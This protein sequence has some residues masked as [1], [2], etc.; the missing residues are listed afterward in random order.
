MRT[1]KK[2]PNIR[3]GIAKSAKIDSQFKNKWGIETRIANL[4]EEVGELAHDV[5]VKEEFL[6]TAGEYAEFDNLT[7]RK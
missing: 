2:S 4:A 5:L 6:R 1:C 7:F 3:E